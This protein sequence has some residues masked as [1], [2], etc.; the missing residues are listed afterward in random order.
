MYE[1][2]SDGEIMGIL[3]SYKD[4][5]YVRNVIVVIDV[6]IIVENVD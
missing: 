5:Y 4:N 3:D 1:Y 2:N 6:L